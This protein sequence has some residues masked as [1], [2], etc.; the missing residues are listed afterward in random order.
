LPVSTTTYVPGV[1]GA[2]VSHHVLSRAM[3]CRYRCAGFHAT[4]RPPDRHTRIHIDD[5][6]RSAG[7][8][9]VCIKAG[10]GVRTTRFSARAI[11][12][13][14]SP[15]RCRW[16]SPASP[17]PGHTDDSCIGGS[18]IHA[19][20]ARG[21]GGDGASSEAYRVG[22]TPKTLGAGTGEKGNRNNQAG[23]RNLIA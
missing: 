3:P 7:T 15:K 13:G 16:E 14:R 11:P 4:A 12:N 2:E 1:R 18:K 20:E 19:L 23:E 9:V 6:E 22:S 10:D 8:N 5:R 21:C 17:I